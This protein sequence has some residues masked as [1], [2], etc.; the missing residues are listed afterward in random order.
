MKAS[1]RLALLC[2]GAVV[3]ALAIGQS[4]STLQI[5][6]KNLDAHIDHFLAYDQELDKMRSTSAGDEAG[7]VDALNQDVTQTTD[8]LMAIETMINMFN[9]I[10]SKPD[11]DRTRP[12]LLRYLRLNS[13]FSERKAKRVTSTASQ[14]KTLAITQVASKI[15]NELHATILTLQTIAIT[16]QFDAT[17]K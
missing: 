14:S 6:V 1:L 5:D 8:H 13:D 7:I 11:R 4:P 17:G 12:I 9:N 15:Q 2:I 10:Q 3:P 16:I